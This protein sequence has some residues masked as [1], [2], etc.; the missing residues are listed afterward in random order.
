MSCFGWLAHN[1]TL[2]R[3][4][5]EG[6]EFQSDLPTRWEEFA[7][8]RD[9][10]KTQTPGICYDAG[11]GYTPHQHVLPY[12]LSRLGWTVIAVD[13]NP[14]TLDMPAD[15]N[16]RRFCGDMTRTSAPAEAF[17][18]ILCIST[19]EHCTPEIQIAFMEEAARLCRPDGVLIVTTDQSQPRAL[20]AL[21]FNYFDVG[22]P[23]P[24][25]GEHLDPKVSY[26]IGRR[27]P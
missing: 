22:E 7:F 12:I 17:D 14:A 16:V 11:S 10:L 6:V 8:V 5:L 13:A 4:S 26:L 18:A 19:L 15:P 25:Y 21:F 2:T 23:S 1:P 20:A 3:D 24:D 9:V 27:L